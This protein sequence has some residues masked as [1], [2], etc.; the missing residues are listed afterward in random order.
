MR[1]KL[2]ALIL[3]GSVGATAC[4]GASVVNLTD[5][6]N[7]G[8]GS[9][10]GGTGSGSGGIGSSGGAASGSS[11][12][13]GSAS[14]SGGGGSSSSGGGQSSTGSGGSGSGSSSGGGGS[15]SSSGG[16]VT[17]CPSTAPTAGAA[18]PTVGLQCEYGSNANP[19]CDDIQTCNSGGWSAPMMMTCASGTCPGSY[20]DVPKGQPCTTMGLDC[21]YAQGQCNCA[22]TTPPTG[23]GSVW[24][25]TMPAT[26]CPE[27]RPRIGS[28][29]AMPGL[30]CDY[31]ACHGGV[32]LDCMNGLW[33]EEFVACP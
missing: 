10:S 2:L 17:G 16:P 14:G 19:A 5:G 33:A 21:S 18:C 25:C 24:Q 6:G 8:S 31:G 30:K 12:G 28:S 7:D 29:C 20:G 27:P 26:G 3:T 22:P 13:G 15:T 11:S 9:S 4:G 1:F 23:L 32:Q